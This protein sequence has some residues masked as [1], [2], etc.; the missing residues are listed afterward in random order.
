M[1]HTPYG[2]IIKNGKAAIDEKT[3]KQIKELFHSYLSG[4]SLANAAEKAG[5]KRY[6]A[7]IS[8]M[9]TNK[10]YIG[11]GFYPQ[12]IDEDVFHLVGSER[13]RRAQMLGR[14]REQEV[15]KQIILKSRFTTTLLKQLYDDPFKQA[16]YAYSLVERE[17][18]TDGE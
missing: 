9:L 11:D 3:A 10:L 8:K 14:V 12:I 1:G 17:V 15:R 2:Y 13:L 16:E 7:S 4:L 5:I 6:H 18:I